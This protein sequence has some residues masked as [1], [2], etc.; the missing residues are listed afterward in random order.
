MFL[1]AKGFLLL[2]IVCDMHDMAC[3]NLSIFLGSVVFSEK[4]FLFVRQEIKWITLITR[5]NMEFS[6]S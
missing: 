5:E 1:D 3:S 6:L 2:T 4:P